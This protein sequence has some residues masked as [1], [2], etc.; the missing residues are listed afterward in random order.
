MIGLV[1]AIAQLFFISFSTGFTG[2]VPFTYSV[3]SH[4]TPPHTTIFCNYQPLSICCYYILL[5]VRHSVLNKAGK[6]ILHD[7]VH[8]ILNGICCSLLNLLVVCL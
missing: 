8:R 2:Y 3:G 6:G 1:L 4:H 7:V 5:C